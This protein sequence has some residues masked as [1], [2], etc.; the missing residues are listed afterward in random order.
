MTTINLLPWREQNRLKAKRLFIAG[1]IGAA[2]LALFINGVW[3]SLLQNQIDQQMQRNA[4]LQ[5][6][7]QAS[8]QSAADKKIFEKSKHDILSQTSTLQE[9][10]NQ[11]FRIIELMQYLPPLLPNGVFITSIH[12]KA[13]IIDLSGSAKTAIQVSDLVK[14]LKQQPGWTNVQLQ[15]I[16][17]AAE[18]VASFR[19]SLSLE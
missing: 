18:P 15:E 9:L 1:C 2:V 17:S 16:S 11:R 10:N 5:Q 8:E 13:A 4:Y 6:Q 19:I 7:V 3:Y 12:F 14:R